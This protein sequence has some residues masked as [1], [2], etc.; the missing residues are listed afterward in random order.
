MSRLAVT[1]FGLCKRKHGNT[2]DMELTDYHRGCAMIRV[3]CGKILADEIWT[4]ALSA[5]TLALKLC[6]PANRMTEIANGQRGMP[7]ET[8]FRLGHY[9][10][11]DADLWIRAGRVRSRS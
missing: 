1:V 6:V 5:N 7:P 2:Y 8:A 11:T 10:G 9:L 4:R 3:H